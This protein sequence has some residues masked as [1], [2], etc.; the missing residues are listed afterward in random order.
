MYISNR[1]R[2]RWIKY[3]KITAFGLLIVLFSSVFVVSFSS[4]LKNIMADEKSYDIEVSL[5]ALSSV[6]KAMN[7]AGCMRTEVMA[8]IR[9][10]VNI[11]DAKEETLCI[12]YDEDLNLISPR[13]YANNLELT[14]IDQNARE[15]LDD[16][17]KHNIILR[18]RVMQERMGSIDIPFHASVTD[19]IFGHP[20]ITTKWTWL[21]LPNKRPEQQ[22]D[23]EVLVLYGQTVERSYKPILVVMAYF[24][25]IGTFVAIL[26]NLLVLRI[27]FTLPDMVQE[28]KQ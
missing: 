5:A 21:D 23:T 7:S 20:V 16:P 15:K 10:F 1:G 28:E 17:L 3:L 12:L 13:N 11:V 6:V 24:M 14:S 8:G 25:V 19:Q 2:E 26:I 27:M 18:T 4:R 22:A 9:A